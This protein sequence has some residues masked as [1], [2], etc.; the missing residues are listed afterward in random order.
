MNGRDNTMLLF[1]GILIVVTWLIGGYSGYTMGG[2]LLSPTDQM[3]GSTNMISFMASGVNFIWSLM[4]FAVH[5]VP[6]WVSGIYDL[7]FFSCLCIPL[8][9]LARGGSSG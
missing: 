5:D 9:R 4:V 7:I 6:V 2:N 3:R 8:F 1:A